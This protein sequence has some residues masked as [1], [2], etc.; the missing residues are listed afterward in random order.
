MNV[1]QINYLEVFMKKILFSVCFLMFSVSALAETWQVYDSVGCSFIWTKSSG[2]PPVEYFN[3]AST[4]AGCECYGTAIVHTTANNYVTAE[5]EVTTPAGTSWTA[6]HVGTKTEGRITGTLLA[7]ET[8]KPN[9]GFKR[10]WYA[11]ISPG[12]DK[13]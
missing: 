4:G 6:F 1:T 8:D 13:K 11:I 7:V 2:T 9:V 12:E 10:T 3:V 5:R